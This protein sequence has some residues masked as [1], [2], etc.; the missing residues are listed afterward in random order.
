V[1]DLHGPVRAGPAPRLRGADREE[2]LT[3]VTRQGAFRES[4][5]VGLSTARPGL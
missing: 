2:R 3:P 1:G 4:S 5:E